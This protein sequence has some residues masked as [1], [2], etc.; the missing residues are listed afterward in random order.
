MPTNI[1]GTQK[2]QENDEYVFKHQERVQE[3]LN[4]FKLPASREVTSSGKKEKPANQDWQGFS[5]INKYVDTSDDR[6]T[7]YQ[8]YRE[9]CK[10]PELNTSINIYA[11]NST[12]KNVKKNVLEIQSENN[13]VIEILES[14][15][16][17]T[18][19]I[20]TNLWKIARN[21][22][23]L[24]DEFM[25]VILDSM[26]SPKH[27]VALERF[28]KP[29]KV[30][31]IEKDGKLEKF[32][33]V[34]EDAQSD[35]I[36]ETP[37]PPWKIVH[38]RVEDEDF[39]PYGKSVLEPGRKIWKKLSLME[40]AMLIY[41]IS[42]APERRVF[43]IDVGT[44]ATKDA[45]LYIEQIKTKFK[46]KNYI[47]PATGE[48]DQKA[49]ALG[50][51][52]DFYIPVRQNSQ[53]TRIETLPPGQ[54]LGE[55]DDVKYF[56]DQILKLL[57]IP[58]AYLGGSSESGVTYDPKSYL[59]QQEMQFARTI[60]RVQNILT[61]GLEKIGIIELALNG[62]KSED[63]KQ[64]KIA[65]TPPS[66]VDQLMEIEV[67]TQQFALVQT[68]R[69]LNTDPNQPSFLPDVWIYKNVLGF[70][71]QEI[72]KIRLQS[73]M[74]MQMN[75]QIQQ[76]FQNG[77]ATAAMSGGSGGNIA[78]TPE[79]AMAGGTAGGP[80]ET[81]AGAGIPPEGGEA[82]PEAGGNPGL[83]IASKQF[84]EFDGGN[85]LMENAADMKK[86]LRYIQMYEDMKKEREEARVS[87]RNGVIRESLKG[88]FGGLLKTIRSDKSQLIEVVKIGNK[89]IQK[90]LNE[91]KTTEISRKK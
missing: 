31:R 35:V 11:D 66:N 4:R 83:E 81:P 55:I 37:F 33:Y 25:E 86:L 13:K 59:S 85:W 19:D 89:E 6:A 46:K 74:Q 67:R 16:F 40:D 38:F 29:E 30:K 60:E 47:N 2:K 39:E 84:V 72:N 65:L 69:T 70:T 17:D 27:V 88:E 90:T 63:L 80:S 54:N 8:E 3:Y 78:P 77:G 48:V 75:L 24:G 57:G 42:R 91:C 53:G 10:V 56:K 7:R 62:I 50:I 28:K 87:R 49:D 44:L 79:T 1:W 64:F 68:I 61:K 58:S 71:D 12:Q 18:L 76:I 36:K 22:C 51:T 21:T 73:Q 41:R 15:Y 20:N 45:N 9:M 23:K 52:E 14:L 5:W 34:E 82:A 26:E 32:V 43:Y